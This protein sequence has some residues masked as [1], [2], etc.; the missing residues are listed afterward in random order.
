MI[1]KTMTVFDI[2]STLQALRGPG[3]ADGLAYRKFPVKT[4]LFPL[5]KFVKD[6][7][8]LL[9]PIIELRNGMVEQFQE[10]ED[11]D[12]KKDLNGEL[13]ELMKTD[14]QVEIIPID[15]AVF[16]DRED[17]TLSDL[18]IL[19]VWTEAVGEVE[20]TEGAEVYSGPALEQE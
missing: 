7:G 5:M 15:I 9:E 10:T 20:D 17:L 6:A 14:F 11:E 13:V 4:V 2:E 8:V 19:E 1:T 12:L 16:E 18:Q 3:G